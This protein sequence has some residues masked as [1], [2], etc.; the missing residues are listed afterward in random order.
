M[1][2]R[3]A[4]RGGCSRGLLVINLPAFL[5]DAGIIF[6]VV[7]LNKTPRPFIHINTAGDGRVLACTG[8]AGAFGLR[9]S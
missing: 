1:P 3:N 7:L 5:F 4:D 9:K 6:P 8:K 2:G